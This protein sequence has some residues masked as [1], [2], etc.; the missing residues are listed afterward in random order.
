MKLSLIRHGYTEGN[1]RHLYYGN[2]ELPLLEEGISFLKE[3]A[4]EYV[5]PQAPHFYTSGMLRTEQTLNALYGPVEHEIIPGIREID[6]GDFEMRAYEELKNDP[7]YQK[8]ISGDVESNICPGGES[9]VIVTERALK[10]LEPIIKRGEDA[11]CITHGGVISGV[12]NHYFPNPKGRLCYV[13]EPGCGFQ[14]E[15][16][17]MKAVSYKLIPEEKDPGA[18]K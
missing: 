8:W 3:L 9:G 16:S 5:Y 10:A 7:A 1:Q 14:I 17:G 18:D 12:A 13:P 6:F 2:T 11:V 15:F 4:E